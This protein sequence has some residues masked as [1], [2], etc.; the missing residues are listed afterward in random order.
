[1]V[2]AKAAGTFE[3]TKI[4]RGRKMKE[5][6]IFGVRKKM[7]KRMFSGVSGYKSFTVF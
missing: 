1:M 2:L 4:L 7:E 5:K 3:E 6:K